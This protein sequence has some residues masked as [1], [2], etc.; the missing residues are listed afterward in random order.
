MVAGETLER[1]SFKSAEEA[2]DFGLIDE[3]MEKRPIEAPVG[4]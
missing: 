1:D 4:T 2:R 3:V